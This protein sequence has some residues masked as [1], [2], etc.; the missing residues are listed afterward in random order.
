MEEGN[1]NASYADRAEM[2]G[3]TGT[4]GLFRTQLATIPIVPRFALVAS[5]A[6]FLLGALAGLIIG[7]IA[8]PPTAWFAV[9]EL[10]IPAG[11]IGAL[12]GALAGLV[13][14]SIRKLT[15]R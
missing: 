1:L 13:V 10:G 3:D 12:I 4:M 14:A 8:Y 15:D 6:A 9:L 11:L 5:A 7:L 2:R